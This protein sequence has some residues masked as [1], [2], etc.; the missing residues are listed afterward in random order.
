MKYVGTFVQLC[1]FV[2]RIE[3]GDAS[4]SLH[5]DDLGNSGESS[6]GRLSRVFSSLLPPSISPGGQYVSSSPLFGCWRPASSSGGWSS[7]TTRL[8]IDLYLERLMHTKA[9]EEH[10]A[11]E[12]ATAIPIPA[13]A[14][15]EMCRLLWDSRFSSGADGVEG[16]VKKVDADV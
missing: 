11:T 3:F 6:S 14:P 16:V 15:A 1:V 13:A 5:R 10:A 8:G 2:L 4:S 7:S 9:T 12:K